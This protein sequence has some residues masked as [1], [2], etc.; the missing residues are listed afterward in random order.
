MKLETFMSKF[1]LK[2]GKINQTKHQ[3]FNILSSSFL[4]LLNFIG[5][6]MVLLDFTTRG[7]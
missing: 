7:V 3:K 5:L 4:I 6:S 1:T 2:K